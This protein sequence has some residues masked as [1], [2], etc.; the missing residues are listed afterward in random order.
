MRKE[1]EK[2]I[3]DICR[4]FREG[5]TRGQIAEE[6][7]CSMSTVD[8]ALHRYGDIPARDSFEDHREEIIEM[9]RAGETQKKIAE[10]TGVSKSTISRNLVRMGLCRGKG[11]KAGKGKQGQ[12]NHMIH[13]EQAECNEPELI[14]RQYADN[15]KRSEKVVIRGKIYQDVSAWYM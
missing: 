11:W 2:M 5:K 6:M 9:Y 1:T 13:R 10:K 14:P 3:K 7:H 15:I 4:L 12:R 8:R